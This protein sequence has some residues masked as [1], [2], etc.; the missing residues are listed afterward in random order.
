M[1]MLEPQVYRGGGPYAAPQTEPSDEALIE[2]EESTEDYARIVAAPLPPGFGITLGNALRPVLPSSLPRA[3]APPGRVD[4]V[5]AGS[6]P[7]PNAR[8]HRIESLLNVKELRL[9]PLPDRPGTLILE[10]S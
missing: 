1:Q 8:E 6:S 10:I 7:T 9:R 3:A 5:P 2:I 4:G